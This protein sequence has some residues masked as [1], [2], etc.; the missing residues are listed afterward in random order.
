MTYTMEEREEAFGAGFTRKRTEWWHLLKKM[1]NIIK[2]R[3]KWLTS[4]EYRMKQADRGGV[5]YTIGYFG[6]IAPYGADV[7][8]DP[9]A[10]PACPY[11]MTPEL[12][13]ATEAV[14]VWETVCHLD[15]ESPERLE[16]RNRCLQIVNQEYTPK[17]IEDLLANQYHATARLRRNMAQIREEAIAETNVA[18]SAV[19]DPMPADSGGAASSAGGGSAGAAVARTTSKGTKRPAD[20]QWSGSWWGSTGGSSTQNWSPSG[21]QHWQSGNWWQQQQH[22]SYTGQRWGSAP[23][24]PLSGHVWHPAAGHPAAPWGNQQHAS[25]QWAGDRWHP[26]GHRT[27]RDDEH[28]V[29]SHTSSRSSQG[30]SHYDGAHR[31]TQ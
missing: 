24:Q 11:E 16:A 31:R 5:L 1:N 8:D 6:T 21:Q 3:Q 2:H 19:N 15:S 13:L 25:Q 27:L 22:Q 29:I 23:Q 9:F 18:T 7:K 30:Y 14:T 17:A 12:A 10:P 26:E 20:P 28:T 4:Q